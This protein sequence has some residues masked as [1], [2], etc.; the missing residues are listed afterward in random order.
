MID[1]G[2]STIC[3]PLNNGTVCN[4]VSV[5]NL[6]L[7]GQGQSLNGIV[8]SNAQTGTYVD[9]PGWACLAS[10]TFPTVYRARKNASSL[11]RA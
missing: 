10:R 5:E 11:P 4:N 7:D 6:I 9:R 2:S 1:L 8:N 3:D